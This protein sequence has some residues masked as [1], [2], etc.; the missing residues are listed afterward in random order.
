MWSKYVTRRLAVQVAQAW[1]FGW[2]KA[3]KKVYG[4]SLENTLTFRDS[5][6]TDYYV[7][8]KQHEKY[9]VGLYKLLQDEKFVKNF[10]GEARI[11][12]EGILRDIRK[13]FKR[14][15]AELSNS[16][17]LEI[18]INF[19]LPKV[20]QFYVRMW[21][22][23]NIAE[24]LAVVLKKELGK[25][26]KDNKVDGCLLK[27]SSQLAPNDVLR[28]RIDFLKIA[29][30]KDELNKEAFLNRIKKHTKK[31]QHI[32]M[33]DFD[34]E[35]YTISYFLQELKD[36]KNSSKELIKLKGL[37]VK[38]RKDFGKIT[39]EIKPNK[40]LKS[41]LQFL[42]ENVFLRDYRDMIRQKLNLELREFYSEIG[43]RL[44]LEVKEAAVLT[45]D[46]IIRYLKN[47]KKFPRGEIKKREKN[48]L[49]IQK[50]NEVKIYSGD[51]AAN[52][53]KKELGFGKSKR[54]KE[55]KGVIACQGFA[56]GRV[57]IIYTN[58]D[59]GKVKEGDII[60]ATMTRQDF[61]P[62]MRKAKAIVTD[63]GGIICHAAVIA[64]ELG[65]PCIVG[66]KVATE[67]L[68]DGD[69]V[70]VDANNGIVRVLKRNRQ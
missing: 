49:L 40:R 51:Q 11:K 16:E 10:H 27:L 2:G 69:L 15:L 24:P 14:N 62:A 63:E 23:F 17:L 5:N 19:V 39:K 18:Y 64:R 13:K 41:L 61:V 67:I 52:K 50:G 22:V 54:I 55:I 8:K 47:N 45:N 36:V 4:V 43:K 65:I 28:E 26:L 48:Y 33:F 58:K 32:P 59:L 7:D 66:T 30:V 29:N 57:K 21:T 6:K 25:S 42:K 34:H 60:V 3:M 53:F 9:V 68:R 37:F 56:K 35:P 12:L 46:E 44:G 1:N 31:Y 20:G 38:N 70:E